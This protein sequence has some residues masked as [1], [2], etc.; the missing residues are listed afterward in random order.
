M[1]FCL[2]VPFCFLGDVMGRV[3]IKGERMEWNEKGELIFTSRIGGFGLRML[4]V[5][6]C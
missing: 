3:R 5:M 2:G 4:M 1:S 6:R